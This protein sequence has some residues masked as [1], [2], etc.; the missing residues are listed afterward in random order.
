MHF[1]ACVI[2]VGVA[3]TCAACGG[4]TN[5]TNLVHSEHIS[6]VTFKGKWPVAPDAGTL[7]CDA[8]KGGSITF[9]PDGSLDVY[10]VNGTAMGG[11]AAQEGWKNVRDI[12]L[13]A[14]PDDFGPNVNIG[15]FIDE[16]QRLCD[17]NAK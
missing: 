16:G 1:V 6:K 8:T 7:A 9:S 3:A 4:D 15:D 5:S 2:A 11:W 12:W 10:A 13:P 14:G 17:M